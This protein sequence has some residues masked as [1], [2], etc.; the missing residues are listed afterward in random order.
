MIVDNGIGVFCVGYLIYFQSTTMKQMLNT[1]NVMSERLT[2]IET[3][4]EEYHGK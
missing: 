2:G 3:R 4:I 1:L